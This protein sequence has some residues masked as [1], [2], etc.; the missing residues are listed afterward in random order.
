MCPSA[1]KDRS[2]KFGYND[3]AHAGIVA[4]VSSLF[5]LDKEGAFGRCAGRNLVT[6]V[7][8]AP[9]RTRPRELGADDE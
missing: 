8:S 9:G 5:A 6:I 4:F 3:F 1:W 2:K 7:A